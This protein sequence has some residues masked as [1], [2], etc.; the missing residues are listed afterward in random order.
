VLIAGFSACYNT[1][2]VTLAHIAPISRM[3]L[4][5]GALLK[6]IDAQPNTR[7]RLSGKAYLRSN[8]KRLFDRCCAHMLAPVL[9]PMVQLGRLA[10]WADSGGPTL[11][12]LP[13]VGMDGKIF[14]QYKIRTMHQGSEGDLVPL[15]LKSRNDDRITRVGRVLR[16]L[17]VDEGPQIKNVLLGDMSFVGNRPLP[18]EKYEAYCRMDLAFGPAYIAG[19]PGITGLQQINGRGG[20]GSEQYI[21]LAEQYGEKASLALDA[22]IVWETFGAVARREGAY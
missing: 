15:E 18:I 19:R 3:I 1:I 14:D 8:Q 10:V 20:V 9:G 2:F 16:S 21:E 12:A 5:P 22:D 7:L 4:S 13:R 17:S 6:E 11:V